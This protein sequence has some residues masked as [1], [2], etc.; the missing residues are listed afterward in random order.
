MGCRGAGGIIRFGLISVIK[1][2]AE[3]LGAHSLCTYAMFVGFCTQ[4]DVV[5]DRSWLYGMCRGPVASTCNAANA[6]QAC[7]H[8]GADVN[9]F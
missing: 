6:L 1:R 2:Q 4:T 3:D 8:T 5:G 7:K 9:S